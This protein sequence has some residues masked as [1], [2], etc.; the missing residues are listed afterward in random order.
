MNSVSNISDLSIALPEIFLSLWLLIFIPLG[1]YS[2]GNKLNRQSY[3]SIFSIIGLLGTLFFLLMGDHRASLGFYD[4]VVT[5]KLIIYLK[6]LI[7]FAAI[8]VLIISERYRSIENLYIFEYPLLILFSILGMLVMLS[9]NN[10][11]T[12]YLGLELQSLALYVL[13]AAKKDSLKSSEAGLKY[14]ILGALASGFFLFGVSLLF[15]ITGTTSFTILSFNYLNPN[16]VSLLLIFS[17]ILIISSIAFKLSI[18]PFHMWT[19]D[20]YEGAPTSITAYFAIVPKIAA[21]GV[22]MRIL[23]IAFI[24]INFIWLQLVL[25][26]GLLSI[27]VGAFGALLQKN[28][29]RL[30]AYSAISNIGYIFL[31]LSLGN[32]LGLES[33]LLYI[34]I[35]A[36]SSIGVFTFILSMEKDNIM[37]ENISSY[38]GLSK[39]NPFYA[40]CLGILLLSMAGLPPLAGFIAKFYVFKAVITSG[41]L[42]TAI[43]GI[44]GSVI[45]AYY[46]L[47]IIK[48]M[49]LDDS[50][51]SFI[52][53]SKVSMKIILFTSSLFILTFIIFADNIINFMTYISRAII[54]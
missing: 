16:E 31:A 23:Y 2:G 27:F 26:L 32:Q 18:A 42:L 40:V 34:T 53:E 25:V 36:I 5:D 43:I 46:Y 20:V 3:F 6:A 4:L 8:I 9:S 14:F 7:L 28:I 41:Y 11:I 39:S 52:V 30:L 24:D 45:S 51:E 35:Y 37:L 21:I 22:L 10:F 48:V 12:L 29:K 44:I 13:A 19:P 33:S 54:L 1:V 50:D 47:N 49:Y 15:G 38:A 17:I